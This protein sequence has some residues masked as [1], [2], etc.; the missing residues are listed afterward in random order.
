MM[1]F[2]SISV[3][4]VFI[5]IYVYFYFLG[6]NSQQQLP[7]QL[8]TQTLSLCSDAPN[9]VCSEHEKDIKHFISPIKLSTTSVFKD[10]ELLKQIVTEM[11]GQIAIGQNN[12]FSATFR[13]GIFGF[14]DD[15]EVR[16]DIEDLKIH[17]RSAS[18]AGRND[19]GVNKQRVEEFKQ[20][21]NDKMSAGQ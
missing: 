1:K 8:T 2:A 10:I 15:F 18:R 3:F 9:C 13:S 4:L 11:G 21:V 7:R 17:F 12:Y 19:F 5:A 6:R 20:R 14:V 16:L